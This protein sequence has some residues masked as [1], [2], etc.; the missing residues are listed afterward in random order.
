LL[1]RLERDLRPELE[2]AETLIVELALDVLS[3]RA[4]LVHHLRRAHRP[5]HRLEQPARQVGDGQRREAKR[6]QPADV[7]VEARHR[8]VAQRL[9]E[10]RL[11]VVLRT[12]ADRVA[13]EHRLRRHL[14]GAEGVAQQVGEGARIH[15]LGPLAVEIPQRDSGA[16]PERDDQ[17]ALLRQQP[18]DR[19]EPGGVPHEDRPVVNEHEVEALRLEVSEV[20]GPQLEP[21][22]GKVTVLLGLG[23]DLLVRVDGEDTRG[24][25]FEQ[26]ARAAPSRRGNP[27]GL[28]NAGA[29][30][31]RLEED[32]P[33]K[34]L[35]LSGTSQDM[36]H[37]ETSSGSGGSPSNAQAGR[38]SRATRGLSRRID[39]TTSGPAPARRTR[40]RGGKTRARSLT[41]RCRTRVA[42]RAQAAPLLS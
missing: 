38:L 32:V 3:E 5:T 17:P 24:P 18:T 20:A 16:V 13:E 10:R 34:D 9:V 29:S 1:G 7:E 27:S 40:R 8:G 15:R 4:C 41:L 2:L 26:E 30:E 31:Q 36:R 21:D 23:D 25:A 19:G 39:W 35:P 6:T 11:E 14:H 28:E 42:W 37:R 12:E 22:A 33:R